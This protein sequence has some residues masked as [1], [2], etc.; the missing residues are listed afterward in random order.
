MTVV[1]CSSEQASLLLQQ[2]GLAAQLVPCA[3]K[4]IFREWVT[5]LWVP[6]EDTLCV[7]NH[8]QIR[9]LHF[10]PKTANSNKTSQGLWINWKNLTFEKRFFDKEMHVHQNWCS[11]MKCLLMHWWM[12]S[13]SVEF[14]IFSCLTSNAKQQMLELQHVCWTNHKKNDICLSRMTANCK[15]HCSNSALQWHPSFAQGRNWASN[16]WEH[17]HQKWIRNSLPQNFLD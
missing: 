16:C 13:I 3:E 1:P 5:T 17:E 10:G 7:A 11:V 2:T 4:R 9:V 8:R 12:K 6:H 15:Q 14:S